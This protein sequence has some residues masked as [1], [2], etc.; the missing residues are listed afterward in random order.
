MTQTHFQNVVEIPVPP[1]QVWP[2]MVDVEKWPEW[3]TSVT[4]IQVL[5]PG[6]LRVGSRAR[7]HQPKLP[8]AFWR[9]T[10]LVPGSHFTWVSRAPGVGGIAQHVVEAT[11]GGSRVTLSL[12][13]EG[14]FG[15]LVARWMH[16]LNIRYLAMEST[17]LKSR[18]IEL[19]RQQVSCRNACDNATNRTE[20]AGEL[21]R[22]GIG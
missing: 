7:I 12:R 13:Y 6:P 22:K 10:E 1:A 8:P 21:L 2:V 3:T 18:C 17:G 11:P 9:V 20:Q 16:D 5:T 19:A 15:P 4:H 14:I